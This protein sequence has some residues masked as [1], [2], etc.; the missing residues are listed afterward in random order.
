MR[1]MTIGM[2][3]VGAVAVSACGSSKTYAN[4]PSPASPVNLTVY[5]NDKSVSVSP[6]SVGS[7]PILLVVTNQA[8][9]AES[10]TIQA[11]GSGGQALAHTGPINPQGTAQVSV[12]LTSPGSYTVS[13]GSGPTTD[14][15]LAAPSSSI[16]PATVRVTKQRSSADTNLLQP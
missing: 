6:A 10:L 14:A 16:R 3:A 5:I 12:N 15:S 13:T 1:K 9:K 2:L 7:C 8:S 11:P 4:N